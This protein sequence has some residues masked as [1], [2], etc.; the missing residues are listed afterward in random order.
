M[1]KMVVRLG[2]IYALER[3]ANQSERDHR[4][5]V[6][7][8]STYVRNVAPINA[9][10]STRRNSPVPGRPEPEVQAI[11]TFLGRRNSKY[12]RADQRLILTDVELKGADLDRANL[13]KATL[14]GA[15]L[16]GAPLRSKP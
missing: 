12:E 13:S 16:S 6:E 8:L 9:K 14:E 4:P 3:I 11:L 2:G 7:V 10:Q 15:D 5:T 1:K